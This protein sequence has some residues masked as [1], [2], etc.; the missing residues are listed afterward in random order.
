MRLFE[1]S[2][3]PGG[4]VRTESARG[5][6]LELGPNTVRPTPELWMLVNALDLTGEA[7]LADPRTPRYVE[8]DGALHALP[9]SP[10][11]FLGTR[12]LSLR[13]K[14][15]ILAE[16]FVPRGHRGSETVRQ[17]FARRLGREVADRIVEPFVAGI[18]AG[19][20]DALA[21]AESF[22]SFARWESESGSILRGAFAARHGARSSSTRPPRGLLSFRAGM[23]TLPRRLASELGDRLS[24]GLRVES[25][26]P[27]RPKVGWTL[28]TS[29]GDVSAAR[30][31]IATPAPAAARLV[32]GFAPEAAAALGSIPH[33]PLAV[34]HLSSLGPAPPPGFGHLVAPQ[35]G[36]RI[37]GAVWS[38]NLFPG[39]APAGASLYTVFLG[40]ARDAPAVDLPDGELATLASRDLNAAL[41]RTDA[42]EAIRVTK[43]ASAI[44]QYDA[45]HRGR[46]ETL[47]A[48]EARF[49]GLEFL[50]SYRGGISVGDVVRSALAVSL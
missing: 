22:P 23:E 44:P 1:A 19:T 3:R 4:V 11:A 39:R 12:L 43:Y 30:V 6:L 24:L 32:A 33:P 29:A 15:R 28:S 47:L 20:S 16:P 8:V 27:A 14:L 7:L 2:Q 26:C 17:F 38:S 18:W 42:F 48:A 49:P 50:G 41:R 46:I 25:V 36:R 5:Y 9:A 34:V 37:L 40:G 35:V 21:I 10:G 45:G 31:V 13:G